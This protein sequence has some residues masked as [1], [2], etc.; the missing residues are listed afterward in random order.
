MET[1]NLIKA[2][3]KIFTGTAITS[4]IGGSLAVIIV[5]SLGMGAIAMAIGIVVMIFSAAFGAWAGGLWARKNIIER[6]D[7][8]KASSWAASLFFAINIILIA[9]S[10][11]MISAY[12]GKGEG[13]LTQF[14]QVSAQSVI[15]YISSYAGASRGLIKEEE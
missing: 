12:G 10:T 5:L 15:V 2:I 13:L 1:T 7:A 8:K 4:L 9:G 14:L 3:T 6:K 11:V